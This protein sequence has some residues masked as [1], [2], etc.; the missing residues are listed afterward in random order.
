[1]LKGSPLRSETGALSEEQQHNFAERSKDSTWITKL[2]FL[3]DFCTFKAAKYLYAGKDTVF[4][5]WRAAASKAFFHHFV[6]LTIK[7]GLQSR[8]AYII[9]FLYVVESYRQRSFFPWLYFFQSKSLFTFC[10]LQHHVHIRHRRD[11]D[12]QK[13]VRSGEASLPGLP[14]KHQTC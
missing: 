6:R 12:E 14:I 8:A 1:M 4:I 13:A 10:S 2:L 3:A 11:Y 5:R 7:I 9:L